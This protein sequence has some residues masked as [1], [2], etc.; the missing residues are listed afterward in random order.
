[1]LSEK[2]KNFVKNK[3]WIA[4][5]LGFEFSSNTSNM[6]Y[7]KEDNYFVYLIPVGDKLVC[8]KLE[9]VLIREA[10]CGDFKLDIC[11]VL[12]ISFDEIKEVEEYLETI[13]N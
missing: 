11:K 2:N 13:E 12:G 10:C 6:K 8:S 5:R 3:L 7:I 4:L 1:M 9:T